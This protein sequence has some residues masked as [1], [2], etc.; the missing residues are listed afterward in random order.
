M[1]WVNNMNKKINNLKVSVSGYHTIN[2]GDGASMLVYDC[3]IGNKCYH[4]TILKI[5]QKFQ[6]RLKEKI[7]KYCCESR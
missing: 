1:V 4:N 3:K 6:N 2:M 7:S 5:S